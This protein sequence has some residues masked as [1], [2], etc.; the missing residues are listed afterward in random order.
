MYL[1]VTFFSLSQFKENFYFQQSQ[2]FEENG[3]TALLEYYNLKEKWEPTT[4]LH[5]MNDHTRWQVAA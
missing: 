2:L 4:I 3:F 1:K 5:E